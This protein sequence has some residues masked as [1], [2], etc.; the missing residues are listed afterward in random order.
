MLLEHNAIIKDIRKVDLRF[1]SCYPNLYRSAMSSLGF[2]IIYDFLN[3][4]EDI[5][6]ERVVY[7]HSKSLETSTV[8]KDFDVVV[9][10]SKF[11]IHITDP[12]VNKGTSLIKVAEDIGIKPSEIL[13]VGDSENDIEFLSAA[14]VKVA[15]SNS[16]KELKDIADYVT[17]NP[18]GNGV[19][20]A[21]ERYIP[22]L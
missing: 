4:R 14:G 20:E 6:C 15:V 5:Y 17:S 3:S 22:G 2:H 16:D 1:A 18:H 12:L 9:Y 7:Q 10:D 13:A 19:K 11:A 21:V 8:L